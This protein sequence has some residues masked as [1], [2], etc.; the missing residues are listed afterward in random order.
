MAEKSEPSSQKSRSLFLGFFFVSLLWHGFQ[1]L[2]FTFIF[3]VENPR[4]YEKDS[5]RRLVAQ[6]MVPTSSSVDSN[7]GLRQ[8]LEPA[9][10]KVAN[11]NQRFVAV[12]SPSAFLPKPLDGSRLKPTSKEKLRP[13]SNWPMTQALAPAKVSLTTQIA[14]PYGMSGELKVRR[15]LNRPPLPSYP[16]WALVAAVE[17]DLIVGL[18]VD[19]SGMPHQ[20][21]IQEGCGDSQTDLLV[22]Q[23]VENMRFEP[24]LGVSRGTIEWAFRLDR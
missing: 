7:Y 19:E 2:L 12:E 8:S 11:E 13:I 14:V 10:K 15:V 5:G 6:V 17:L 23:Y 24:S 16:E 4:L 22:L 9:P 21:F 20:V 1:F 18:S 3:K